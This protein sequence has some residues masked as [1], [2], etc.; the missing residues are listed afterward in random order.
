VPPWFP[1]RAVVYLTGLLFWARGQRGGGGVDGKKILGLPAPSLLG[2]GRRWRWW[3]VTSLTGTL[4]SVLSI[5]DLFPCAC[6]IWGESSAIWGQGGSCRL[7]RSR[8]ELK[9][10]PQQTQHPCPSGTFHDTFLPPFPQAKE[11]LPRGPPQPRCS[12]FWLLCKQPSARGCSRG[13]T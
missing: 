8:Q 6:Y 1:S 4:T 11:H 7:H 13:R 12:G 3:Q 5:G 10:K 9:T 2:R